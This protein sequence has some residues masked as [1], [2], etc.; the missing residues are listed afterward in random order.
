VEHSSCPSIRGR[1]LSKANTCH[2]EAN[3]SILEYPL[4]K[5]ANN[6]HAA[7][8]TAQCSA[9][10]VLGCQTPLW[11]QCCEFQVLARCR[12][13]LGDDSDCAV[14]CSGLGFAV[15]R[16]LTRGTAREVKVTRKQLLVVSL[17]LLAGLNSSE[18]HLL[19]LGFGGLCAD[20]SA[21]RRRRSRRHART[22]RRCRRPL[23]WRSRQRTSPPRFRGRERGGGAA[24]EA[25]ELGTRKLL[26][27]VLM[28]EWGRGSYW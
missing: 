6:V 7:T 8:D 11:S 14:V 12:A 17:Q 26:E 24:M 10:D 23:S 18:V 21:P 27:P 25:V 22:P 19:G 20:L 4:F 9:S 3:S 2:T 5:F 13:D 1:C 16:K 15:Q 28:N